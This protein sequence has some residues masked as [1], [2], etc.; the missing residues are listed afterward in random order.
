MRYTKKI[1]WINRLKI[2]IP[3]IIV[4]FFIGIYIGYISNESPYKLGLGLSGSIL[5]ILG[6]FYYPLNNKIV[7]KLD[8]IDDKFF[9]NIKNAELGIKGEELM[10][11]ELEKI[12]PIGYTLYKNFIIPGR[13]FDINALIVGPKGVI[14][15]EV[16]N[17]LNNLEIFDN[18]IFYS[19]DGQRFPMPINIDPRF[20]AD[21]H[22]EKLK[23]FFNK[24]N[25]NNLI[26]NK[27]V[28]FTRNGLIHINSKKTWIYLINGVE[29]INKYFTSLTVD[30]QFTTEFC[31]KINSVLAR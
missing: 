23:Q 26:I 3:F 8:R 10:F 24:N 30:Q 19:I 28:V 6:F 21:E 27:A 13:K 14:I 7:N 29:N 20:E 5:F 12:L 17:L 1:I 15:L 22:C 18:R 16:K 31:A 9:N 25:I 11:F 4:L 2:F